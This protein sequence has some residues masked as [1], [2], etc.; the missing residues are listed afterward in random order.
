MKIQTAIF[1][2][3]ALMLSGCAS[4][5]SNYRQDVAYADDGS[6]DT[7]NSYPQD[8][9]YYDN[10]YYNDAGYGGDYYS[11]GFYSIGYGDPFFFGGNYGYCLPRYGFCPGDPLAVFLFPIGGGRYWLLFDGYDNR[12]YYYG[13]GYGFGWPYYWGFPH[14][15]Y[16]ND[17]DSDDGYRHHHHHHDNPPGPVVV[18]PPDRWVPSPQD[19]RVFVTPHPRKGVFTPN[20]MPR[21]NDDLGNREQPRSDDS[22]DGSSQRPPM[23]W[24]PPSDL[25]PAPSRDNSD[26]TQIRVPIG[27]VQREE[28][29][30]PVDRMRVRAPQPEPSSRPEP[31]APPT[32]TR[33]SD[34]TP[35]LR[36]TD[37]PSQTN[38]ND[39]PARNHRR[40]DGSGGGR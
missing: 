38:D 27:V 17:G 34:S 7:S 37:A 3:I 14:N 21:P 33:R 2:G 24:R 19:G 23:R 8:D 35:D 5:P 26:M 22:N 39:R 36:S 6:Y 31:S 13:G 15:D 25:S 29:G 32:W 12:S 20:A 28:S 16:D 11:G 30:V 10:G 9:G 1:A 40:D 18:T 4:A